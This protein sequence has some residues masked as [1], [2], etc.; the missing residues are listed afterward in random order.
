MSA[1]PPPPRRR[2]T[3][4]PVRHRRYRRLTAGVTAVTVIGFVVLG[5][6]LFLDRGDDRRAS[7]ETVLAEIAGHVQDYRKR[8]GDLPDSLAALVGVDTCY[9]GGVCPRDAYGEDIEYRVVDRDR[10]EFRLRSLG[11]DRKGATPDDLI[12]PPGATWDAQ[13]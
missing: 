9:D 8:N 1:S 5:L 6:V 11:P 13:P 2:A 10:F 7:T 12:W 3:S 4:K